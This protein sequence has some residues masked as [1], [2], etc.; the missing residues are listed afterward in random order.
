MEDAT[1][2]SMTPTQKLQAMEQLWT[3]L[4]RDAEAVPSPVWHDEVLKARLK[5][6]ESGQASFVALEEAKRRLGRP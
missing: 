1:I 3:A 4:I 5:R 2:D 6:I